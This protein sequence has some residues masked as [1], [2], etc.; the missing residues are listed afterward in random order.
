MIL[1]VEGCEKNGFL[2]KNRMSVI[3]KEVIWTFFRKKCVFSGPAETGNPC[4]R[5]WTGLL[6]EV[7]QA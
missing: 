1:K 5:W 7:A 2:E 6:L 3:V 4:N